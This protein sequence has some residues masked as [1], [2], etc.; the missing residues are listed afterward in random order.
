MIELIKAKENVSKYK[1]FFLILSERY[2]KNYLNM[3]VSNN[4]RPAKQSAESCQ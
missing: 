1:G 4:H 3:G 2:E